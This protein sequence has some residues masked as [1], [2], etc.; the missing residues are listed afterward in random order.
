MTQYIIRRLLQMIPITLGI[1]TLI[2]SLIHLIPGDPAVQ[3]AGEGARPEDVQN[4]R[5]SLGLDQPLWKQYV[6]YIGNLA[7]GDLGRSF[8]T[9]ESVSKEIAARY[10][11]TMQLAFGSMLVALLV[12]FPL[13]IISAIYRNSWIDNLARFFALIGV[14]MPSFW[15]GPLLIIAFAI[16]RQWFPVSG[17]EEGLKSLVLPSITMGLALSAILTRMIRVSLA[18]ELGQLYVTTAIAKGV[19]R[20]KAI[21]RHALKN[22]LIPVITILALQFGSLLTGAIITEQIFSWPGLGRLL[23]QSITTRD[24]PQVQASILVIALTYIL[25]NFLSDLLYGVVDPRIKLQ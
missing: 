24:Y 15:F 25:V 9:N 19:T 23:I 18:D 8:R 3:I 4:V 5:K 13:G 6:T 7:Q 20:S 11:A 21:F 16:N 17:R 10:P 22:A 14:S 2:F 1:L 12:A